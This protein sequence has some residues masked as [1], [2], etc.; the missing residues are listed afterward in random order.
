MMHLKFKRMIGISVA[1]L[2]MGGATTAVFSDSTTTKSMAPYQILEK[3]REKYASLTSYSD[4]GQIA[5]AMD[6]SV[7]TTG[8]I[9]RLARPN[10]YRIEWD[11]LSQSS[12][13]S[14]DSG[15]QAIWS[16]GA[17]DFAEMGSGGLQ[18]QASREMAFDNTAAVFGGTTITVPQMF[19]K[20]LEGFP[21]DYSIED[22]TLLPDDKI[23]NTNC[24]VLT[25]QTAAG[26]TKTYWVGTNDFL[27]YQVRIEISAQTMQAAGVQANAKSQ[28]IANLHAF[29][30]V[31][32]HTNIVLN[33]QY[34][35]ADFVPSFPLVER[36]SF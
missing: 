28:V 7:T 20:S 5:A 6:G 11:Q 22:P 10:F 21:T 26:E 33:Q 23:G 30:S 32:T 36:S 35:R 24:Y 9:T 27:I 16:D 29:A 3:V 12:H 17:G 13:L 14:Q 31:E 4:Q 15:A 18:R 34:S 8:F 1:V 25:G 2:L 19:F